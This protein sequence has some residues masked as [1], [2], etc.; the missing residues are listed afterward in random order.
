MRDEKK[1][2]EETSKKARE[3]LRVARDVVGLDEWREIIERARE[4]ALN[5]AGTFRHPA[6]IFPRDTLI[7]KSDRGDTWGGRDDPSG[8]PLGYPY[9]D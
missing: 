4:D 6:R 8:D 1:H 7:G 5:S 3:C 9:D 2:R